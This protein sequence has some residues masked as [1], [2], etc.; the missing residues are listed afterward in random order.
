MSRISKTF[1][2][3]CRKSSLSLTCVYHQVIENLAAA[4]PTWHYEQNLG[5]GHRSIA[6]NQEM[7]KLEINRSLGEM[8]ILNLKK[9]KRVYC[10]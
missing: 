5:A 7:S 8:K 2:M 6:L 4:L 1:G 3:I 10:A 9:F